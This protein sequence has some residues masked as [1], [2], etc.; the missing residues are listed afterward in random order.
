MKGE[1]LGLAVALADPQDFEHFHSGPN[2]AAI[3]TL[4]A[5]LQ[6]EDHSA[7]LLHGPSGTGKSH[8]VQALMKDA[9][10]AGMQATLID[11]T[12]LAAK[13]ATPLRKLET[14]PLLCIDGLDEVALDDATALTL[15]RLMDVRRNRAVGTLITARKPATQ[16]TLP[17]P[18]LVTRLAA[19]ASFGL[20]PLSDEHRI[21][22]LR[23]RASSRGLH[24]STEVAHYLLKHLARDIGSLL[25]AIDTLD[26]ASLAAQRRL[27]VPFVQSALGLGS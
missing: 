27:T 21:E 12:A 18:D 20:K 9:E 3:S 11:G 26:R 17:R 7:L 5:L 16:Q 25:A 14:A 4:R 15:I 24:L 6:P 2:S 19:F 22:L 13:L 8:L 23:L 1:Q 10:E